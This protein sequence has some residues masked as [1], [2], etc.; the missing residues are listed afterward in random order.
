[1]HEGSLTFQNV[2]HSLYAN[3]VLE[4]EIREEVVEIG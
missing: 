4:Q 2:W 3:G 1:M